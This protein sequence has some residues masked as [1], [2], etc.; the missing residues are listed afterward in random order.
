LVNPPVAGCSGDFVKLHATIT[1]SLN[2]PYVK[3]IRFIWSRVNNNSTFMTDSI[4]DTVVLRLHNIVGKAII[5]VYAEVFSENI[6][7]S[8]GKSKLDTIH[9]NIRNGVDVPS[10]GIIEKGNLTGNENKN[11]LLL[12]CPECVNN[13]RIDT[14]KWFYDSSG[15][16]KVLNYG[17]LSEYG[18]GKAFCK[19]PTRNKQNIYQLQLVGKKQ[20]GTEDRCR[21]TLVFTFP[22]DI[23]SQYLSARI[24]PNPSNGNFDIMIEDDFCGQGTIRITDLVGNVRYFA[25]FEKP[26]REF[27]Y[28]VTRNNLS[29]GMYLV[30]IHLSNGDRLMQKIMVH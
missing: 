10:D 16:I 11:Y 30:E 29:K 8:C 25:L 21:Q 5:S 12:I 22:S 1:D 27:K 14:V 15:V 2:M 20:E 28:Q 7:Y 3:N 4:A 23:S 6:V 24:F 18:T 19:F 26:T 17:L 13:D 9:I